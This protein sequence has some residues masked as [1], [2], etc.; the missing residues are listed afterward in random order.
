MQDLIRNSIEVFTKVQSE[1]YIA[2]LI[3]I[4]LSILLYILFNKY[5]HKILVDLGYHKWLIK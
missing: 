3:A 2:F 4:P 1:I 5:Q